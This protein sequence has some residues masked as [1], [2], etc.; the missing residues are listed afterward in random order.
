VKAL[1]VVTTC[2]DSTASTP[3]SDKSDGGVR[4]C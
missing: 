1:D 3:S 2:S 4:L